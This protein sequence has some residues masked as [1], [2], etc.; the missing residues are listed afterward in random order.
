MTAVSRSVSPAQK[1]VLTS[2]ERSTLEAICNAFLPVLTT[3]T[4]DAPALFALDAAALG[5]AAAMEQAI[6]GLD[7]AQRSQFRQLLRVLERPLVIRLLIGKGR[8]FRALG[9]DDQVQ[10]L[11]KLATSRLPLL[12]TGF[13]GLKRLATFLFYSVTDAQGHNP[14]WAAIGYTPSAN[15]PAAPR[16]LRI[17]TI[18]RATTMACDVCVIGSGAGGSVVAAELAAAGKQVIV[19]EAGGNQQAPDFVQREIS[20]MHDLYL[21][22]GLT[23][24]RDLG[25]AILAGATLG[26][27]TTVNWQ[28]SLRLADAIRDE[29]AALSGC[30]HFADTSFTRSFELVEAR[31]NVNTAESVINGNNAALRDGCEALGYRWAT[32]PRNARACAAEQC[33]Y[34][35]YGCR[36]GGKQSTAV[37]YLLDAQQHGDACIVAHCRAERVLIANGRVAGVHAT[38]TDAARGVQHMVRINAPTVVVAAGAIESP[39]L[40]LRSG[41]QLPA[42]GHNLFLHPVSAVSGTYPHTIEPWSGPPQTILSD[43]FANLSGLYGFRLETAPAH[44]GLLALATPWF[45][46]RQHRREMQQA[47]RKSAIIA[48][49]R[50]RH[51]GRV[52]LSRAGRPVIEYQP[53][54]R[55]RAY[56]QQGVAAAARVHLA[57]GASDVLTLHV[58]QFPTQRFGA[59]SVAAIDAYC[60]ALARQAV[61]RNWSTIFSAHQMG[62]CRMGSDPRR[63]VCDAQ[64]QVFGVR[65][66]FVADGSAFPAS[67]GVNPMLTIMALAHHTAQRIKQVI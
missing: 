46:P 16:L 6:G 20:G 29:W 8:G 64:G 42:L 17:T 34:C 53:G 23:S 27:G 35:V 60:D 48:L 44:P 32:L 25:V 28:T 45:G 13:Q 57:A 40:L 38:V 58:R 2:A 52:R 65:G 51:G 10:V 1:P 43:Q 67:S 15:P 33:G 18:E 9:Q 59:R 39:A 56:L 63:A 49:V 14:T 62:T 5:V 22:G 36:H 21:D 47:A 66:L 19:L 37:T 12:R 7:D 41:V 11:L 3:E 30:T 50:D 31:L 26:G 61:D 55:E 24:S 4:G 54:R